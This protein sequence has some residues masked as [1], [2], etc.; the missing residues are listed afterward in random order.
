MAE[1]LEFLNALYS[2]TPLIEEPIEYRL[3]YDDTGGITMC[4]KQKHP[5]NTQY[6]IVNELEYENYFRYYVK[7]GKLK[8]IDVDPGYRVQLKSSNQGYCVVKN[9]AS[10]ILENEQCAEIEHYASV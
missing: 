4:S 2:L 8:K 9:H 3:H 10:I 5:E 1:D 6:L 7:D